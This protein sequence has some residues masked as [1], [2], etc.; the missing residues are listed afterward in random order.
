MR[1]LVLFGLLA[2]CDW[3]GDD[4]GSGAVCSYNGHDYSI[5]DVFPSGDGC[6]SCSCTASGVACTAR[7]C[8]DDGGVDADPAFCGATGG[9]PSGPACGA[10]CCA[11]GE[12]C[13]NGM[14]K[15]GSLPACGSGDSCEAPGPIG[16][17]RCGSICCGS[18]GPCP[19]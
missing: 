5:G 9:C 12:H 19:Q 4:G 2:A 16:G 10:I 17:D 11:M 7:A 15:C 3:F 6:N 18:S 8:A 13:D 14:C 1:W